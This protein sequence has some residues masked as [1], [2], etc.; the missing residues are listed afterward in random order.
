[1]AMSGWEARKIVAGELGLGSVAPVHDAMAGP[2]PFNPLAREFVVEQ[3]HRY[4]VGT[5]RWLQRPHVDLGQVRSYPR[6]RP[7]HP[8]VQQA[9]ETSLG[10]RF[11]GW[12]RYP[13]FDMEQLGRNRFL[14][15]IVD[16]RYARDPGARFGSISVPVT[17]PD[18]GQ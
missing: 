13:T 18:T 5:F 10:R 15:H 1:M 3:G 7:S 14:V 17:L 12:A 9:V 4:R 2:V 16:L 6:G 11:M 8:A